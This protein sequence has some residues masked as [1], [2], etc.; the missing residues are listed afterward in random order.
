MHRVLKNE[1]EFVRLRRE[2]QSKQ[3]ECLSG[4]TKSNGMLSHAGGKRF[5]VARSRGCV[6][7]FGVGETAGMERKLGTDCCIPELRIFRL[8]N[9]WAMGESM[10]IFTPSSPQACWLPT[11]GPCYVATP[12]APFYKPVLSFQEKEHLLFRT[13]ALIFHPLRR[14]GIL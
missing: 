2:R 3:R 4:G 13:V 5:E 14:S 11:V 1:Q 7:G 10:T 6:N 12:T 9:L 8:F